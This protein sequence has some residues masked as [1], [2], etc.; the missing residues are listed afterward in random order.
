MP[1]TAS[2]PD[3]SPAILPDQFDY[4]ANLI[5]LVS[6]P[7]ARPRIGKDL[8]PR[9]RGKP[10][11]PVGLQP[12]PGLFSPASPDLRDFVLAARQAFH[13]TGVLG[14]R[15]AH[16]RGFD[17]SNADARLRVDA[18]L[19]RSGSR[20]GGVPTEGR[21][22]CNPGCGV[23]YPHQSSPFRHSAV[24]SVLA[25]IAAGVRGVRSTITSSPGV[26]S[27]PPCVRMAVGPRHISQPS[28]S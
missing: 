21:M 13:Q 17:L 9:H 2:R 3:H 4:L 25:S 18:P 15:D 12:F 19:A 14:R 11:A 28:R 6:P 26:G 22:P 1:V 10:T 23:S 16:R 24:M 7:A 8:G 5:L 27:S 20:R